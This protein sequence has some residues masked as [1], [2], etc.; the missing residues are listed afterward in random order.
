MQSNDPNKPDLASY[1][2]V[3]PRQIE[4][5]IEKSLKI[6]REALGVKI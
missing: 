3:T 6:M 2:N 4:Y 1:F 5:W